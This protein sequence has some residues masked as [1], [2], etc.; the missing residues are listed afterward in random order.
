[1]GYAVVARWEDGVTIDDITTE[2]RPALTQGVAEVVTRMK[3][4]GCAH[5][6]V[7]VCAG[8]PGGEQLRVRLTTVLW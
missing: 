7:H 6:G 8:P 3:E 1:M 5:G 4:D 2:L